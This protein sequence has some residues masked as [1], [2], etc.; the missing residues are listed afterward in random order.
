MI[1]LEEKTDVK[2]EPIKGGWWQNAYHIDTKEVHP[3]RGCG[4]TKMDDGR[5]LYQERFPSREIAESNLDAP[6]DNFCVCFI[7]S[8]TVNLNWFIHDEAIHFKGDA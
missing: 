8:Q 5:W 3:S 2:K 7:T 4:W 1:D 6:M